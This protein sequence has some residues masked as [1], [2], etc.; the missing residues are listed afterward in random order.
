[1]KKVALR[2]QS[3][4]GRSHSVDDGHHLTI[5]S[6]NQLVKQDVGDPIVE[7]LTTI[8]NGSLRQ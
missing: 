4:V 6:M 1:M 7:P 3:T 2:S 8:R 5:S